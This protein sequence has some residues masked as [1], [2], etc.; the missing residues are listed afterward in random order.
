MY[1]QI[2]NFDLND[3]FLSEGLKKRLEYH[4]DV[5]ETSSTNF[6]SKVNLEIFLLI[7]ICID[8]MRI[9][10]PNSIAEKIL[11]IS[12]ISLLSIPSWCS[13]WATP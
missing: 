9:E 5:D 11:S 10:K 13:G 12:A 1:A 8:V 6:S 4:V 2:K 3:W 7:M